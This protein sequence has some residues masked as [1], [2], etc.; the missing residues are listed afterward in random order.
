MGLIVARRRS[1]SAIQGQRT[2]I[3]L[4]SKLFSISRRAAARLNSGVSRRLR[5]RGK[6]KPNA[7]AAKEKKPL[8]GGVLGSAYLRRLLV[9]MSCRPL[10]RLLD[11]TSQNLA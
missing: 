9:S 2:L 6:K 1:K 5:R 10:R 11:A 3:G 8:P 4:A 7:L